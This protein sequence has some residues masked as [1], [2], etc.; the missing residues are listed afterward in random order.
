MLNLKNG[1]EIIN[2]DSIAGIVLAKFR[3]FEYVTWNVDA[4]GNAYWGHYFNDDLNA[5]RID[6]ADRVNSAVGTKVSAA[7]AAL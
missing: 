3:G 1:A 2:M 4:D 5:A 7:I 6:Y